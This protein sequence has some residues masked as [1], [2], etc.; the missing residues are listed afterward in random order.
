MLV[1]NKVE[2][3]FEHLYPETG[4]GLTVFSPLKIGILTGKY[5]DGIPEDSRLST[6]KDAVVEAMNKRVGDESWKKVSNLP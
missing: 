6:S 4:L 5:N 2:K 3:E 1:R